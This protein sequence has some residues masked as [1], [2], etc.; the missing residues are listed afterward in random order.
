MLE[1]VLENDY[2]IPY[3]EI[4]PGY[5]LVRFGIQ[6]YYDIPIMCSAVS[7]GKVRLYKAFRGLSE[8]KSEVMQCLCPRTH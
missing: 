1:K 3:K 8:L 5:C 7:A 6:I 2:L 4:L